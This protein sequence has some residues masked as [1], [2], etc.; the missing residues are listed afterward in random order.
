MHV[1]LCLRVAITI[2]VARYQVSKCEYY[3]YIH[4]LDLQGKVD[5]RTL[6]VL[7]IIFI[8][9]LASRLPEDTSVVACT[10]DPGFSVSKIARS[11]PE[12]WA[13][14]AFGKLFLVRSTEEGSRTLVHAAVASDRSMHGRY[15]SCCQVTEESDFL[16]TPEG[17]AFSARVWVRAVIIG[18]SG[19]FSH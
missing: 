18:V 9:E 8:R 13:M 5:R 17:K 4:A 14:S 3:Y 10:V 6:L 16:F 11:R 1:E 2:S 7:G 12:K 15:L 19:F